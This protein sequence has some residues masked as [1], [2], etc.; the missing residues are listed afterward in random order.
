M[1]VTLR[2]L[3]NFSG[4]IAVKVMTITCSMKIPLGKLGKNLKCIRT[5][6]KW[7]QY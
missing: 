4:Q 6:T 5:V 7:K 3:G 1:L 2:G